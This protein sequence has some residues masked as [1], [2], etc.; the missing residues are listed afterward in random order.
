MELLV[1]GQSEEELDVALGSNAKVMAM[2]DDGEDLHCVEHDGDS[3]GV[4]MIIFEDSP[5]PP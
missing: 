2:D 4:Y 1:E 5:P 3:V